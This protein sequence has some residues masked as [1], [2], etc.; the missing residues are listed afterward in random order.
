MALHAT[1]VLGNGASADL[2]IMLELAPRLSVTQ[3]HAEDASDHSLTASMCVEQRAGA[4]YA[5]TVLGD[6]GRQ[7][8]MLPGP[9]GGACQRGQAAALRIERLSGL[10]GAPSDSGHAVITLLVISQ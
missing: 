9:G 7:A 2:R 5:L 4:D 3:L 1:P 6:T 8:T 10:W